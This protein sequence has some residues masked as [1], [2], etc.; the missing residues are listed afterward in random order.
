MPQEKSAGAVVFRQENNKTFYLL[1]CYEAG[2]WDF[3]KGQIETEETL[4]ETA[5]RE[6]FE[7]TG[8]NDLEFTPGFKEHIKYF[9]KRQDKN[10]FK[11]VTFF[12]AETKTK[13]VKISREHTEYKWLQYQQALARLTF[14]NAKEILEK[15]NK[16]LK[17][18]KVS[19]EK[20]F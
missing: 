19:S 4:E 11:A 15:A 12:L 16:F 18:K 13:K 3:P 8:I 7:E 9:Y 10:I 17:T 6:I 2:H 20:H 14:K 1:L 5:R